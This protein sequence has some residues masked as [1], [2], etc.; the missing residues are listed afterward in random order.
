MKKLFEN[1]NG[2]QFKLVKESDW[3]TT[4]EHNGNINTSRRMLK[5]QAEYINAAAKSPNADDEVKTVSTQALTDI[6]T[7]DSIIT[8]G[9]LSS[10]YQ[11]DDNDSRNQADLHGDR[12][13]DENPART[14]SS[15]EDQIEAEIR[16]AI[17]RRHLDD[18]MKRYS[19][20]FSRE[21]ANVLW[22]NQGD[23]FHDQSMDEYLSDV[24]YHEHDTQGDDDHRD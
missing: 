21:L 13:Q 19:Q 9:Y 6:K 8:K 23:Q 14:G 24:A 7:M 1:V 16:N 15:K 4:Q 11:Y 3:K 18:H 10:G 5:A 20:F 22:P 2:N 17:S 12:M